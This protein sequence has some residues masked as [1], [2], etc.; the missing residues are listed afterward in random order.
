MRVR[1]EGPGNRSPVH[2]RELECRWW[3]GRI[4]FRPPGRQLVSTLPPS[5]FTPS[6]DDVS[7]LAV[8][9]ALALP[10]GWQRQRGIDSP[11]L[12]AYPLL[13]VCVC[14]FLLVGLRVAEG[15]G[16]GA[17]IFYG[18]LTGIGFVGSGAILKSAHR[19]VG[20]DTA[21]ALWV[22]GAIGAG[23][24]CGAPAVSAALSAATLG[25]WRLRER[26]S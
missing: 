24:A 5:A 13:S 10:V 4:A 12:R 25:L 15:P 18:V 6:L 20:L 19:A 11:G 16:E 22:T 14:G 3:R 21:V 23:V 1:R 17:D 7:H 2:V 26:R 8:A 9:F